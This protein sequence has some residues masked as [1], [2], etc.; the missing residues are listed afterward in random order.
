MVPLFGAI[1]GGPELL[2]VFVLFLFMAVIPIG[3]GVGL[4]LLGRWSANRGEDEELTRLQR[5][6][7]DLETKLTAARDADIGE[8]EV[9]PPAD[10][11]DRERQGS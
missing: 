6:I 1:P 4:F 9:T 7:E 2:I 3:V 11:S 10:E 5:R 8:E